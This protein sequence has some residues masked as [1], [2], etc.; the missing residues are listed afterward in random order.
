MTA[1]TDVFANTSASSF[2][3]RAAVSTQSNSRRFS[4]LGVCLFLSLSGLVACSK[5]IEKVEE[6]LPVRAMTIAADNVE[7]TLQFTGEVRARVESRLGFRV[8]GKIVAR[9]VDVGSIVRRGQVLMQLDPQDLQLAQRQA[10]A[11]RQSALRNRDLAAAELQRYQKLRD[12]NFVSQAVLDAKQT[13]YQSALSSYDQAVA[14]LRNQSNQT[15]YADL[16]ADVDGVVTAIDA[17]AG[18]VVA[19]GTPVVSVA[20]AGDKD[21]VIGVPEDKVDALRKS[22]VVR[23]RMWANPDQVIVGKIREVSPIADAVTRT[24]PFKISLPENTPDIKLGMTAYVS[25]AEKSSVS[26]IRLPL[27]AL[28]Q[29]NGKPSVWLVDGGAVKL[30]SVQMGGQSGNDVLIASGLTPG[31]TV[32]TAGVNL[33]K[34]G[35]KVKVLGAV[36]VPPVLPV[37]PVTPVNPAASATSAAAE[38]S[39]NV[40]KPAGSAQ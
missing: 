5:K 31:Q 2:A 19:A 39:N 25:F 1:P 14:A 21:V 13:A 35:Q 30:V 37:P 34:P 11:A 29:T 36:P 38:A 23:V 27:T 7:S 4:V 40:S 28:H 3:V 26:M 20:K 8:G 6:V 15:G 22:A 17:E 24:Y 33:L 18:Q 12:Q 16:L 32:V 10:D 9:K